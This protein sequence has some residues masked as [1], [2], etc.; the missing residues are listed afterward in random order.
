MIVNFNAYNKTLCSKWVD[1]VNDKFVIEVGN[2]LKDLGHDKSTISNY[3]L[4]YMDFIIEC[5]NDNWDAY[6]CAIDLQDKEYYIR[7]R[8]QHTAISMVLSF[9]SKD[10]VISAL[11]IID[12]SRLDLDDESDLELFYNFTSELEYDNSEINFRHIKSFELNCC[13]HYDGTI[14]LDDSDINT[15]DELED[16][17]KKQVLKKKYKI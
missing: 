17:L 12:D 10:D 8:D 14:I 2:E 4:D 11:R 13:E 15:Y 7:Y 16:F 1:W 5:K 3:Y 6:D 9:T